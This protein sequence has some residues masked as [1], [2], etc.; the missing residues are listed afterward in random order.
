MPFFDEELI[1]EGD[2]NTLG[3]VLQNFGNDLQERLRK[4]LR[5]RTSKTTSKNLEQ[6]I[7]FKVN[8][9]SLGVWSFRLVMEDYGD[10]IDQGV[11]GAGGVKKSSSI[12]TKTKKGSPWKVRA[13]NSPFRFRKK[14]P[15]LDDRDSPKSWSLRRWSQVKGLNP[16]AVQETIFRQGIAPTRFYSDVVTEKLFDT[17]TTSL[18]RAGATQFELDLVNIFTKKGTGFKVS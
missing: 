6:S 10:F 15:P 5:E 1:F 8:M 7:Q 16:Y 3:G 12:F 9:H 4:S 18:E 17:L 13:Q 2:T 11:R 14:K